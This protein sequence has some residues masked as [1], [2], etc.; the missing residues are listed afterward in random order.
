MQRFTPANQGFGPD[1]PQN[2]GFEGC[3]GPVLRAQKNHKLL[4]SNK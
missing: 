1:F 2:T 3:R 4:I